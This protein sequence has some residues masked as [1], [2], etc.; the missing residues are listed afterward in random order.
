MTL[1]ASADMVVFAGSLQLA[2]EGVQA[3]LPAIDEGQLAGALT[4]R[5][6][7][8][9]LAPK[10]NYGLLTTPPHPADE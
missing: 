6:A 9:V 2:E 3:V 4:D 8:H 1:Q 10:A 5:S 7:G